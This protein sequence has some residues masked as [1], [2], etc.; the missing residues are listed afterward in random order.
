MF[1]SQKVGERPCESSS[2]ASTNQFL[3]EDAL[4]AA[5]ETKCIKSTS[6]KISKQSSSISAKWA[7]QFTKNI[8]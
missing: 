7:E 1:E 2:V 4:Q 3:I 5:K 6:D 8:S